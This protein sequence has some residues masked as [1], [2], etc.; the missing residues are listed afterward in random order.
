MLGVVVPRTFSVQALG[1]LVRAHP[2]RAE[3]FA[4]SALAQQTHSAPALFALRAA[5]SGCTGPSTTRSRTTAANDG[6]SSVAMPIGSW[7]PLTCVSNWT[8]RQPLAMR[9]SLVSSH[10]CATSPTRSATHAWAESVQR[11]GEQ[12]TAAQVRQGGIGPRQ[13][14]RLTVCRFPHSRPH[15]RRLHHPS[16]RARPPGRARRSSEVPGICMPPSN[17][18]RDGR[19]QPEGV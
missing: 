1:V 6:D 5:T 11:H 14:R 17:P 15:H 7:T 13:S 12:P 8:H 19:R 4:V 9:L 10:P 3:Q 2:R 16:L 18:A